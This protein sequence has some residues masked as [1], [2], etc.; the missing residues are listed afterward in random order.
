VSREINQR[1]K[2]L[3]IQSRFPEF[4]SNSESLRPRSAGEIPPVLPVLTRKVE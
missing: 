1:Q 4:R 2:Y 3:E